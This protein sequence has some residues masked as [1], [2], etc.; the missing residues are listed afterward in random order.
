GP[1]IAAHAHRVLVTSFSDAR[2][3]RA[4]A[5]VMD[6]GAQVRPATSAGRAS[7]S[8]VRALSAF[9]LSPTRVLRDIDALQIP[10]RYGA[11]K[12]LTPSL[13]DA[14]HRLGVE[15]H[16]WTIN[17]ADHMRQLVSAGV[18]GIVTDRADVAVKALF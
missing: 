9:R 11:V 16:V 6:A 8:R 14:A 18:D 10:E 3:L 17:D 2:R 7:M 4:V 15:V 1:I 5:A 13:V 12:V